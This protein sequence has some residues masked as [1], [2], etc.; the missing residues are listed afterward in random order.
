MQG[1]SRELKAVLKFARLSENATVPTKASAGAAGYD[2]YRFV[3]PFPLLFI[4]I[5][6]KWKM[7]YPTISFM[8]SA[9][10][11]SIGPMEKAVV[12]TDIQIAVPAA[13]RSGL[14]AN[15]FIDVGAG[16]I[17]EDYRG[18]VGVVLFNFSKEIFQVKKG[19]RIAQLICEKI[20]HAD[21]EQHESTTT[22]VEIAGA[23]YQVLGMRDCTFEKGL[24]IDNFSP[25]RETR[26][27]WTELAVLGAARLRA[28]FT[29]WAPGYAHR[30]TTGIHTVPA[31]DRGTTALVL[32]GQPLVPS[33]VTASQGLARQHEVR[34]WDTPQ[35]GCQCPG[36]HSKQ[37]SNPRPTTQQAPEGL[38]QSLSMA[39]VPL[40]LP[41]GTARR[42]NPWELGLKWP[43]NR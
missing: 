39:S 36:G 18:N 41:R 30:A 38:Q 7:V 35:M 25:V 28:L 34:G 12:N 32:M 2:L 22:P 27:P 13:P 16:V 40:F 33:G 9:H 8:D 23:S 26:T 17:D 43:G 3:K 37:D 31:W 5:Y 4:L 14:A 11:C 29:L 21:L 15:Y 6:S 1:V 19:D 20:C 42:K 24:A 10:D